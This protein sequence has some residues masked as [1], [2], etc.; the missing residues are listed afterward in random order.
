MENYFVYHLYFLNCYLRCAI[1]V[2]ER[3]KCGVEEICWI[4]IYAVGESVR[5]GLFRTKGRHWQHVANSH[6]KTSD[7][8]CRLQ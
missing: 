6:M 4:K 5:V 1:G 3:N 7:K 8:L 2:T